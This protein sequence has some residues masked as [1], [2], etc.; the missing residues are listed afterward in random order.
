MMNTTPEALKNYYVAI[1]GAAEDVENMT[2]TVE[3]LNAISVK[4]GGEDGA[5][6][7]P[8]AIE[9]I[10]AVA[11]GGGGGGSYQLANV[12]VNNETGNN[13]NYEYITI[14]KYS[15]DILE[16]QTGTQTTS[17]LTL[18]AAK[19]SMVSFTSNAVIVE[20]LEGSA[21]SHGNR[22]EVIGDCV[23]KVTRDSE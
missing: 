17:A 18:E 3:V 20:V 21:I 5:V 2:T 15:T 10:A 6:L 23:I 13:L 8:D 14:E 19:N 12:T 1:G 9:N 22:V 16:H 11:G 7:N 4:M